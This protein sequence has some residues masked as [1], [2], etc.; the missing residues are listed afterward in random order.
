MVYMWTKTTAHTQCSIHRLI[1]FIFLMSKLYA[2][3][4]YNR[5]VIIPPM[6]NDGFAMQ[7]T[8]RLDYRIAYLI[9]T[10]FV[11]SSIL[12]SYAG[13]FGTLLPA[14]NSYREYLI[15]GG[16]ILFQGAIAALYTKPKIWEYL[17]NMM[18]ISIAGALLLL[19][20]LLIS[21]YIAIPPIVAVLYFMSVAGLMFLE[22]IRRTSIL[23][24]G[25]IL[26]TTWVL[27]RLLVLFVLTQIN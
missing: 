14:D 20:V 10:W 17:G 15:C 18:T 21:N 1:T 24:L 8:F 7:P 23:K 27:Y 25:W 6:R 4:S 12:S 3:I 2:F 9:F 19:P 13:L 5:R 11:T 22:H 16:Q 26:T